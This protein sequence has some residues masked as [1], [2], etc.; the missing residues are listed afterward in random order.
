M[1]R[2]P[3]F[4]PAPSSYISN[5]ASAAGNERGARG[6]ETGN[7]GREAEVGPPGWCTRLLFWLFVGCVGRIRQNWLHEAEETTL[8]FC[9]FW[10]R[11]LTRYIRVRSRLPVLRKGKANTV[12]ILD[13]T[14][15]PEHKTSKPTNSLKWARIDEHG[16]GDILQRHSRR[17]FKGM[18]DTT[19]RHWHWPKAEQTKQLGD[20]SNMQDLAAG[21]TKILSIHHHVLKGTATHRQWGMSGRTL[22]LQTHKHLPRPCSQ[23]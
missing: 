6:I 17:H 3:L 22:Q 21:K 12:N 13:S 18:L 11:T 23:K 20:A 14:S 10:R 2:C 15:P 7:D 1:I 4:P 9:L 5:T 19:E 16:A 8:R